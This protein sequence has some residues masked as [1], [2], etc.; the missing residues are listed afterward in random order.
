[1][2]DELDGFKIGDIPYFFIV[3]VDGNAKLVPYLV[4][5]IAI[6]QLYRHFFFIYDKII[7][8]LH[9]RIIGRL[10]GYAILE[11]LFIFISV[12]SLL[13]SSASGYMVAADENSEPPDDTGELPC[14]PLKFL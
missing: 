13:R 4:F 8:D 3:C 10:D 2:P 11:I 1:H 7:T 9:F 6:R 5:F 14:G 12:L